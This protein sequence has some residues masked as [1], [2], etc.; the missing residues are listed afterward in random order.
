MTPSQKAAIK[1]LG[2]LR[3]LAIDPERIAIEPVLC[4]MDNSITPFTRISAAVYDFANRRWYQLNVEQEIEDEEWITGKIR[5]YIDSAV[6]LF[7]TVSIDEKGDVERPIRG[8]VKYDYQP[9]RSRNGNICQVGSIRVSGRV[10]LA[11]IKASTLRKISRRYCG[12]S[13]HAKPY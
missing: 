5:E 8:I 2:Q 9:R 11:R 6:Q 4:V 12:R 13:G 10:R 3:K 1:P 7:N